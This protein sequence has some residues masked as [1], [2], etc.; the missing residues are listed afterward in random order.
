MFGHDF[1]NGN[2]LKRRG[3]WILALAMGST[4]W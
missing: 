4:P 1:F 3:R 2:D